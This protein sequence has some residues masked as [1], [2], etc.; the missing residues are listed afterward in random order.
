MSLSD[1]STCYSQPYF[2]CYWPMAPDIFCLSSVMHYHFQAILFSWIHEIYFK[3]IVWRQSVFGF[4]LYTPSGNFNCTQFLSL[5][6]KNNCLCML[7]NYYEYQW[8]IFIT[9]SPPRRKRNRKD[10]FK[11]PCVPSS[12]TFFQ[13]QQ[14]YISDTMNNWVLNDS[15]NVL[16]EEFILN[17]KR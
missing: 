8:N 10:T 12:T 9:Y 5:L 13:V 15:C 16:A 7:H 6:F 11:Q 3:D 14:I 2:L 4:L 1:G 17:V